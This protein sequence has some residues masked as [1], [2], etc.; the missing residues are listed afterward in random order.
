MSS[1]LVAVE[2][3]GKRKVKP[4]CLEIPIPTEAIGT[5]ITVIVLKDGRVELQGP[6]QDEQACRTILEL[7]LDRL[8]QHHEIRRAVEESKQAVTQ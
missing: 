8:K 6:L 4:H 3:F 2:K 1:P 5:L 7:G